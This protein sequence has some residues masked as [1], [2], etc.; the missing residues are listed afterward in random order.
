MDEIGDMYLEIQA[1]VLRILEEK[2]VRPVGAKTDR[3]IDFRAVAATNFDLATMVAQYRFRRD[4][5][6]RVEEY[7]IILPPLRERKDDIQLLAQHFLNEFTDYHDQ[8]TRRFSKSTLAQLINHSWTGNIRELKNV[9]RR[10]AIRSSQP[11]IDEVNFFQF[12]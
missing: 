7:P 6:F 4:L 10:A 12:S 11:V 8:V 5:Y 2:T 3:K 1:K 9:V